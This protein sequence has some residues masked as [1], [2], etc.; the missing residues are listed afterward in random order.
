M[1]VQKIESPS[2]EDLA[3]VLGEDLSHSEILKQLDRIVASSYFRNS[4]RYPPFLRF[5]V[6]H[7]LS[8]NTEVLKERTLGTEVFA[9]PNDYDTNADP[10]V[11]VTAGEIRKRIAQYYQTPGHEHELHIDLPLGSYV[12]QFYRTP[13]A[14]QIPEPGA[15][16]YPVEALADST[17]RPSPA[18]LEHESIPMHV[19]AGIA[20]PQSVPLTAPQPLPRRRRGI[21]MLL[22]GLAIPLLVGIALLT[23]NLFHNRAKER[24]V[25]YFWKPTISSSGPILIVIGVH[26]LDNNG[27]SLPTADPQSVPNS[28]QGNVLSTLQYY[29]MVPVS[30]VISYSKLTDLITRSSHAYQ[31]K[32]SAHTNLEDLL[33]GPVI[34][35]G[36]MDNIWTL[37]LTNALRYR[38]Y[39]SG[40]SKYG[41]QDSAH[42]ATMWTVDYL[43]PVL[44]NSH[45]YAIV[46]SY[47]DPTIEQRVVVA[48]GIGM[49]GTIAASEFLTTE[50]YM[51]NWLAQAKLKGRQNV[52]LVLSTEI[53]DGQ[54]GPPHVLA[55]HI[56]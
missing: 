37:R 46:A 5:V 48:A 18:S 32:S 10:I 22:T 34:L 27:D 50:K 42:P 55:S 51:S 15:S 16:H 21:G 29:D 28:S 13:V 3:S 2:E 4:K 31:T 30:D 11:R 49:N 35:V 52:E 1:A 25:R 19:T 17:V 12:P 24:A 47:F 38:F 9:R 23:V 7:T 33:H 6:E 40:T 43:Q 20:G 8:G 54:P 45:D 39:S 26:S 36:G 56:W 44:D 14:G 53:L 41:I